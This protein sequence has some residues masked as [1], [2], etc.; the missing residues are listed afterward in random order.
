[1]TR[2]QL[3]SELYAQLGAGRLTEAEAA[4]REREILAGPARLRFWPE[5]KRRK[6]GRRDLEHRRR[7]AFS[8]PLP[9]ALASRFTVS[10]LAV[11]RIV[12]DTQPC[13][14]SVLEIATRAGVS[15]RT[16]QMT[17]RL[18]KGDGLIQV[19][20][21]RLSAARN[22]TNVVTVISPEWRAWIAR[23]RQ[24]AKRSAPSDRDF[25]KEAVDNGDYW[26]RRQ[27]SNLRPGGYESPA[28]PLSYSAPLV[29]TGG[30]EPP[31]PVLSGQCSTP[32]LRDNKEKEA[33]P[34][35]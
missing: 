13:M 14:M 15:T 16:V 2:D 10:Q 29:V 23:G 32:E 12:A 7:L 3:M 24:G 21:R 17:I 28:L 4:V 22:D 5:R 20:E 31:T 34:H 11:L 27:E 35:D 6:A 1:M 19:R 26:L 18:A 9:P 33:A 30:F 25:K 8:G